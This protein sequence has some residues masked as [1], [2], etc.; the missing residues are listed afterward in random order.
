MGAYLY[1]IFPSFFIEKIS[2]KMLFEDGLCFGDFL[3]R[4][5]LSNHP[6]LQNVLESK[7]HGLLE[8]STTAFE[9]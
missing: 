3:K 4:Y 5:N 8:L 6:T 2:A 9:V 7:K 1:N